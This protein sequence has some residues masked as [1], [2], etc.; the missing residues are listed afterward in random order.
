MPCRTQAANHTHNVR[1]PLWRAWPLRPGGGTASSSPHTP[2]A[3]RFA[4]PSSCRSALN[5]FWP[6]KACLT[7]KGSGPRP[8]VHSAD[9]R[10]RGCFLSLPL[11]SSCSAPNITYPSISAHGM[12]LMDSGAVILILLAT[13][14]IPVFNPH[15]SH[16]HVHH[17]AH[18]RQKAD[19]R[20]LPNRRG[21]RSMEN[22]SP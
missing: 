17:Y 6:R 14:T 8:E 21:S 7:D 3:C 10:A 1:K 20:S 22:L 9:A 13:A 19:P 11:S 18:C 15:R 16:G 4:I 2:M 5:S 12:V